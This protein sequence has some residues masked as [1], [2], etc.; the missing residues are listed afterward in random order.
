M[1]RAIFKQA[2]WCYNY[3]APQFCHVEFY[4][5]NSGVLMSAGNC[6]AGSAFLL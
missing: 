2:E 1:I 4:T 3:I 6:V 5:A